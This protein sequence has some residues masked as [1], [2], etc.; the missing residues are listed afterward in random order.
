MVGLELRGHTGT[1]QPM[2]VQMLID[3]FYLYYLGTLA[4]GDFGQNLTQRH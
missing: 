3:H 1:P 4:V 2:N